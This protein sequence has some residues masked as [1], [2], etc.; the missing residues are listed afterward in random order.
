MF[1]LF[2][3]SK[4]LARISLS[5]SLNK[6]STSGLETKLNPNCI[7]CKIVEKTVPSDII[8]EDAKYS[9]FPDHSPAST[10][11]YLIVPKEHLVGLK[12]L[13]KSDIP[14]IIEMKQIGLDVLREKGGDV[15]QAIT[16]FHWPVHQI[17]HLHMH[18]I[19]PAPVKGLI[20]RIK[21]SSLFFG[22]VEEAIQVLEDK[23]K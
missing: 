6:M 16:G 4:P 17:P 2:N 14:R 12:V 21:F 3:S 5:K 20:P 7:F 13:D 8:Y 19:S 10:H 18:I 22:S 23:E 9:M 15:E 1:T 11:H